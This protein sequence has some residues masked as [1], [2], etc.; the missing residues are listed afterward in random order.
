M[1]YAPPPPPPSPI[2][3]LAPTRPIHA[4]PAL[5][6][7]RESLGDRAADLGNHA[8]EAGLALEDGLVEVRPRESPALVFVSGLG[9][10][11]DGEEQGRREKGQGG[12][13][14]YG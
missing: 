3:L 4:D 12:Q 9:G 7:Q 1:R 10:G 6:Q 14:V 5:I 13:E 8:P 2:P 11:R